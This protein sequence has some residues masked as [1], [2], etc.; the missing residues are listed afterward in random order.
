[1]HTNGTRRHFF[2][3][4]ALGLAATATNAAA[5][6]APAQ[7]GA[8]QA[9][10]RL[11]QDFIAALLAPHADV[12]AL[13]DQYLAPNASVRWSDSR[14]A[15]YGPMAAADAMIASMP[16]GATFSIDIRQIFAH[17]PLVATYRADTMKM[18]GRPDFS[19][20]VAGVHVVKGGKIVEYCDYIIA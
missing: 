11:V 5:S 14:P 4:G 19:A 6:D 7:S 1:M 12:R 16:S 20:S 13:L 10:I 3:I 15:V 17:G 9:N 18:P 2:A 8:E